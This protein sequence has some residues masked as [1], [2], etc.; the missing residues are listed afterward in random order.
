LKIKV[1]SELFFF[2]ATETEGTPSP[3]VQWAKINRDYPFDQVHSVVA[4][5]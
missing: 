5:A 4:C 3:L 2:R 1:I